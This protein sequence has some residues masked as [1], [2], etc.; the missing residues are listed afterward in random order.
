LSTSLQLVRLQSTVLLLFWRQGFDVPNALCILIH[1]SITGEES[2]AGYRGDRLREPFI[3]V[4]VCLVHKRL[5]LDVAVEVIGN[6][7]VVSMVFNAANQS[8]EGVGVT[9][10]VLLDLVEN[11]L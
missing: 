3:L 5:R 1:A 2:H 6:E 10:G 9:E 7:V 4:L 11:N 8:A